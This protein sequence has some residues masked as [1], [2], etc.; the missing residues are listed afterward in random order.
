MHP[1]DTKEVSRT[2]VPVF[3]DFL[4]RSLPDLADAPIRA[5][6]LCM[7][8]DAFDGDLW[9]DRHPDRPGVVVAAGGSGHGFK[10]APLL[11]DF[12]ADAVRGGDDPR[13]N[14]WRWRPFGVSASEAARY[15]GP[16]PVSG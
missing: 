4:R 5:S 14:R 1:N 7:Y 10:F 2:W 12:I 13:R 8:C 16:D 6:R 3:R 15:I 11:G 9:I